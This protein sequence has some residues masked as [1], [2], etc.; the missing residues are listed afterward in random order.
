MSRSI[1]YAKVNKIRVGCRFC[2]D[3][4]ESSNCGFFGESHVPSI[5]RILREQLH[6]KSISC[7]YLFM[8]ERVHVMIVGGFF[9]QPVAF[10][11]IVAS[12]S[13]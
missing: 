3:G 10:G 11:T 2:R 5:M 8:T 13:R 7:N 6:I 12:I 1:T 9:M 4:I